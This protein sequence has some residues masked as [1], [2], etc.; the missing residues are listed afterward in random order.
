MPATIAIDASSLRGTMTGIPRYVE[1]LIS[2]LGAL[3]GEERLLALWRG[4]AG[5]APRFPGVETVSSRMP[6]W[7]TAFVP[8]TLLRRRCRLVHFPYA[9]MPPWLPCPSVVTVHDLAFVRNPGWFS[10]DMERVLRDSW[11]PSIR[12]ADHV[13]CVSDFARHEVADLLKIPV[14]AMTVTHLGVAPQWREGEPGPHPNEG[15]PYVLSV[16]TIQPRKNFA[17]LVEAFA[18]AELG[19][20]DL[21]IAGAPGWK[22]DDLAAIAR[23]HGVGARL[24]LLGNISDD[25]LAGW[26]RHAWAFALPSLYEGFGLP[27]V[28]AMAQGLACLTSN[29]SSLPEVAGEAA[30][31]VE[32]LDVYSIAEGL[33]RVCLDETLRADL[34]VKALARA[35]Q[36]TWER[37]ARQTLEAYRRL[38]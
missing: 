32:P 10:P 33:R 22:A 13:V 34:Q 16:G 1:E 9:L 23:E 24:R 2:A 36:F 14:E 37:C 35:Q 29:Y 11:L 3:R 26:Y 17:R 31:L 20:L 6:F 28:E 38:L 30:V 15:R 19:D 25:E 21:C 7:L 8:W 18:R 5:D 4:A 27:L 12:R